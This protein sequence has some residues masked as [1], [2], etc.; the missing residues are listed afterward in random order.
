[1][2]LYQLIQSQCKCNLNDPPD[3]GGAVHVGAQLLGDGV[4]TL[5]HLQQD[6]SHHTFQLILGVEFI[7][8]DKIDLKTIFLRSFKGHST[9]KKPS[10]RFLRIL[11]IYAIIIP[12]LG[13]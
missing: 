10:R 2:F 13:W 6:I 9:R 7:N 5:Q 8:F 4:H 3:V 11:W 12:G 1:M